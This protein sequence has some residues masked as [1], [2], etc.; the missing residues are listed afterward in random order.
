[1]SKTNQQTPEQKEAYWLGRI[2]KKANTAFPPFI[3]QMEEIVQMAN[4]ALSDE[5]KRKLRVLIANDLGRPLMKLE[6]KDETP[7][8]PTVPPTPKSPGNSESGDSGAEVPTTE[9]QGDKEHLRSS[10]L[11]N[12]GSTDDPREVNSGTP[13]KSGP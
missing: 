11:P 8:Q 1:M 7:P 10:V 5:N 6:I 4:H 2:V 3:A 13:D 12:T 9:D